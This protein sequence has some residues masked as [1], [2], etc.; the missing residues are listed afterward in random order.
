MLV[1]KIIKIAKR[2][3]GCY[4]VRDASIRVLVTAIKIN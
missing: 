4:G 3:A 1:I 2:I